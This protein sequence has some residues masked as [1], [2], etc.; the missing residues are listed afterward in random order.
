MSEA[1]TCVV[2]DTETTDK[3]NYVID[4]TGK[5]TAIMPRVIQ[6]GY[7]YYDSSDPSKTKIFDQLI[8]IDDSIEITEGAEKVHG[9][10]KE[11]IKNA[12]PRKKMTIEKALTHFLQDIKRAT[13]VVAHNVEFDKN[14]LYHELK[15]LAAGDLKT[16]GLALF[17]KYNKTNHWTCTMKDNVQVCKLQSEGQKMLDED[18]ISKG[19]SPKNYYKF[20][21]LKETYKHYFG[22]KPREEAL[23]DAIMDVILCLRV[24]VMYMGK[25]DM[26][27]E[28]AT[29]KTYI[30]KLTPTDYE[31]DKNCPLQSSP[32]KT[33]SPKSPKSSKSVKK[34]GKK[35]KNTKRKH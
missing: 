26:C 18:L 1:F 29:L 19:R 8:D 23:H 7:I 2:F 5:K 34:G 21:Q 15:Q 16:E 11:K 6:L 22:Y 9:I 24:F 3:I 30:Q 12:S 27:N 14:V 35:K 20:P 4:E 13:Y 17:D 28:D 31:F 25:K 33:K 10:S 32:S